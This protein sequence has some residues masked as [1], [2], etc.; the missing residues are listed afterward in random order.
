M[1]RITPLMRAVLFLADLVSARACERD[2][3]TTTDPFIYSITDA[4]CAALWALQKADLYQRAPIHARPV[5]FNSR[6]S[7]TEYLR[8]CPA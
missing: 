6:Q 3:S 7:L 2:M 1:D 8:S 5:S 4:G